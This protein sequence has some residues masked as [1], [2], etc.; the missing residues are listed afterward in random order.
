VD[1]KTNLKEYSTI[2]FVIANTPMAILEIELRSKITIEAKSKIFPTIITV[3]YST[4][5]VE[6]I[7][8]RPTRPKLDRSSSKIHSSTIINESIL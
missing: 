7:L 8:I 2:K 5:V 1:D 4:N 3:K 6:Y